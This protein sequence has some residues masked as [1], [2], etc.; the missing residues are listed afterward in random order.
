MCVT[1]WNN[2]EVI[3]IRFIRARSGTG[4]R[5]GEAVLQRSDTAADKPAL[6]KSHHGMR[7]DAS[8]T[9]VCAC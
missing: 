9:R 2:E 7:R 8:T 3:N 6:F 1:L 5:H 4:H